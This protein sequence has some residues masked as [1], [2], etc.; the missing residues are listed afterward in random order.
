LAVGRIHA[1]HDR[2]LVDLFSIA[3][4]TIAGIAALLEYLNTE[5]YEPPLNYLMYFG[6]NWVGGG[7]QEAAADFLPMIAATMQATDSK[8]ALRKI[9]LLS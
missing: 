7:V 6:S 8:A 1:D 3:P 9:P 4:T 5:S 2:A